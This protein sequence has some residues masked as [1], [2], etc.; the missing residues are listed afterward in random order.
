MREVP[1]R[2]VSHSQACMDEQPPNK[3]GR[4]ESL[5]TSKQDYGAGSEGIAKHTYDTR[6]DSGYELPDCWVATYKKLGGR[7]SLSSARGTRRHGAR[8]QTCAVVT[9]N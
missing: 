3:L 5:T 2:Q 6:G 9:S 4:N 7:A 8:V 1:Y